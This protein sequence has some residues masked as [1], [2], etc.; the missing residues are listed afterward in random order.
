MIS[1]E[2]NWTTN[3]D[4]TVTSYLYNINI[5][6]YFMGGNEKQLEYVHLFSYGEQNYTEPLLILLNENFNHFNIIYDINEI[7][8][9]N[10]NIN[11]TE[12]NPE[13]KNVKHKKNAVKDLKLTLNDKL[14][15]K[16]ENKEEE[17]LE[18]LE[19]EN[20]VGKYKYE[21]KNPFPKYILGE[22]ENLYLNI[23]N[24]L[25]NGLIKN[26]RVWPNYIEEI[27]DKKKTKKKLIF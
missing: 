16:N 11:Q 14:K 12:N 10:I 20:S 26:K 23:Y 3:I 19:K 15:E 9:N 1:N 2:G 18:S 17:I 13:D 25:K 22:D 27:K 7:G 8:A 24:Y 6:I 5:A 4:I 21:L